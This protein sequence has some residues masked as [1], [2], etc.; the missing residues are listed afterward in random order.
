MM[1]KDVMTGTIQ[2]IESGA[3]IRQAAKLMRD[4]DVGMLPVRDNEHLVGTV[5]DRDITVRATA[6]SRDPETTPVSDIMTRG[7]ISGYEDDETSSAIDA[8]E[9]NQVRRLVVLDGNDACVG[10]V[11]IGDIALRGNEPEM[12][13]ELLEEV[14]KPAA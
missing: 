5:T 10:I 7:I 8:M 4:L 12:A 2:V 13:E 9:K 14:S 3:P 11:S 1:L 6:E